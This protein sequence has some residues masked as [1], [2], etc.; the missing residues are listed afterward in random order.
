MRT[1]L[2]VTGLVTALL[3]SACG[4]AADAEPRPDW[5]MEDAG[6]DGVIFRADGTDEGPVVRLITE[7]QIE[8]SNMDDLAADAEDAVLQGLSVLWIDVYEHARSGQTS[9]GAPVFSGESETEH[10][11]RYFAAALKGSGGDRRLVVV[12]D[13]EASPDVDLLNA[14]WMP[15]APIAPAPL[16]MAAAE[17]PAQSA[18]PAKQ[19]GAYP[20]PVFVSTESG[21]KTISNWATGDMSA[22]AQVAHAGDP[23]APH[24]INFNI[25]NAGKKSGAEL[26]KTT[27]ADGG[28]KS[29]KYPT[30]E[31]IE[32]G[33]EMTGTDTWIAFGT[34][35]R[36]GQRVRFFASAWRN[37]GS[38]TASS[39]VFDAPEALYKEWGAVA[40]AL[41]R[42]SVYDQSDFSD[43]ALAQTS[44]MSP[45]EETAAFEEHYTA[46]MAALF[47]GLMMTNMATLNTM[48][49]FNMATGACAGD[50]NCTVTPDGVGG[51]TAEIE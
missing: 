6:R 33:K 4:G 51:Y 45:A 31:A 22:K 27:L 20:A 41:V 14:E 28:L 1:V 17:T 25:G 12:L 35:K 24:S 11:S 34:A 21:G 36:N 32:A 30:V 19:T 7:A 44:A 50:S 42:F 15:G 26:I 49:S 9:A 47:Q 16:A 39:Y 46:A 38:D 43:E 13:P 29:A 48:R 5:A 2:M 8:A 18:P 10:G 37:A 23:K 40:I 3:V